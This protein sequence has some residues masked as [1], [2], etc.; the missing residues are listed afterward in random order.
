M[1]IAITTL[2]GSILFALGSFM[3]LFDDSFTTNTSLALV[4]PDHPHL[5]PHDGIAQL[6][7]IGRMNITSVANDV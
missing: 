6:F 7:A 2:I 4:P 1:Q 3:W 5:C